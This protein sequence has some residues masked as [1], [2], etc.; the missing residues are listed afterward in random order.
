M[1]QKPFVW[2]SRLRWGDTDA[3]GRVYYGSLFRHL[4][5]AEMEFLRDTGYIYATGE[6]EHVTFPRVHA[7]CDYTSALVND[8]LMDIAV[9][10]ERVGRSSFTLAFE[11]SV[12]SRNAAR[13]KVTVVCM[14]RATQKATALP[15]K[16]A[17]ALRSAT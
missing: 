3:S 1:P 6:L 9:S 11:V 4:E 2:R 7:E 8:D 17:D 10:V 12:E 5:A 14:D 13:G 16:F 15:E